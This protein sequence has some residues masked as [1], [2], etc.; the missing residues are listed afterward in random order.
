MD[1]TFFRPANISFS[2]CWLVVATRSGSSN[3]TKLNW[4]SPLLICIPNSSFISKKS[5]ISA[6]SKYQDIISTDYKV[7]LIAIPT[8]KK[9]K[10]YFDILFDVLKKLSVLIKKKTKPIR[11]RNKGKYS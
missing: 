5:F 4:A 8:E 7:H 10:P 2:V 9:R 1:A 6:T 11:K 3:P